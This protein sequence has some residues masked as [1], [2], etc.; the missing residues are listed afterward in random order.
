[1]GGAGARVLGAGPDVSEFLVARGV[2]SGRAR[3]DPVTYD[4]PCHLHHGQRI[5]RAA[6]AAG[7]D[8]GAG[9]RAAADAEECC[10]GAGLYGI[11]HPEL[12]GRILA[13]KVAAIRSTGADVVA[14]PNPGCMMQIGAGLLLGGWTSACCTRSRFWTKAIAG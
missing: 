2:R 8:P 9:A 5:G 12:G 13:D 6:A 14:T 1:V 10:G 7:L 3:A 11:N 4:A